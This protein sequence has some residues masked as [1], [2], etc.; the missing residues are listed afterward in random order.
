MVVS[1]VLVS[2]TTK[3]NLAVLT[4]VMDKCSVGG[5]LCEICP[6]A[7]HCQAWWDGII[8]NMLSITDIARAGLIEYFNEFIRGKK[9]LWHKRK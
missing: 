4:R 9:W 1:Q 7:V 5:K 2:R 3:K 6:V 8:C